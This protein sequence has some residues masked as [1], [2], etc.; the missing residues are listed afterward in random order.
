MMRPR[1]RRF[2]SRGGPHTSLVSL[3]S[4]EVGQRGSS[5]GSES[6]LAGLPPEPVLP[7]AL[8]DGLSS[9]SEAQNLERKDPRDIA[10]L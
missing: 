9:Q 6:K 8:C 3:Q 4:A 5:S 10:H 1:T 2:G 7:M